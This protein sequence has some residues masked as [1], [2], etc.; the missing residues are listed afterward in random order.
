MTDNVVELL[1]AKQDALAEQESELQSK[2]SAVRDQ[3]RRIDGA[4]RILTGTPATPTRR[5]TTGKSTVSEQRL[6]EVSA[7]MLKDPS[8]EWTVKALVEATGLHQPT[9]N[10]AVKML[11][12]QGR[13]R[14][15]AKQGNLNIYRT[16]EG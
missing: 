1:S 15:A 3:K 11:R 7:A 13:I 9:V 2:L 14:L 12:D 5:K 4:I 10:V 16:L 6:A 8:R